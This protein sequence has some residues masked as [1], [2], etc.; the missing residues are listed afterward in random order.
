[1]GQIISIFSATTGK[2]FMKIGHHLSELS[3]KEKEVVFL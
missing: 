2:H 1:M 3:K